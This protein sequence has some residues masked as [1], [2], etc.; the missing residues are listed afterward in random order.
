MGGDFVTCPGLRVVRPVG[1]EPMLV[2]EDVQAW[3][4][5]IHVWKRRLSAEDARPAG[6][7]LLA[8]GCRA[9]NDQGDLGV[10]AV[11]GGEGA[12][13]AGG[14]DAGAGGDVGEVAA[15]LG[16]ELIGGR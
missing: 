4:S 8:D 7:E 14:G 5:S 6:L 2:P 11:A 3:R 12:G 1:R 10:V 9:V 15:D 13:M 16:K